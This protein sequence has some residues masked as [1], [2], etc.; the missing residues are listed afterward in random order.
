MTAPRPCP[1]DGT[2]LTVRRHLEIPYWA[3]GRCGGLWFARD[4][5]TRLE[6]RSPKGSTP[7]AVA[8]TEAPRAPDDGAARC[9]CPG[10]PY[11]ALVERLG[12]TIDVCP[13]CRGVW[14]DPG[15]IEKIL[16]CYSELGIDPTARAARVPGPAYPGPDRDHLTGLA[17]ADLGLEAIGLLFEFLSGP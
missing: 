13:S 10:R 6:L 4:D 2:E 1:R 12:V 8:A 9:V 7:P 5:L 14:L 11:M 16:Q 3:C 17:A 15:E